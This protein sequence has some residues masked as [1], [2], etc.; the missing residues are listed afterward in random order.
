MNRKP[1]R[2][3]PPADAE[4]GEMMGLHATGFPQLDDIPA[5]TH[6]P[7][8]PPNVIAERWE[9]LRSWVIELQERFAHLDHHVIPPC[10]W[11]HNEHVEALAALRDH[12]RVS[13]APMAPA[14]A[15][16]EWMRALRDIE[17]L[18]RTWTAEYACGSSH[19]ESPAT[20]HRPDHTGWDEHIADDCK[21]RQQRQTARPP[22]D[23]GGIPDS[24]SRVTGSDGDS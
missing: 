9:E 21:R 24:E 10:W 20:L 12:E 23:N 22:H 11:R 5:A 15:S 7:K 17:A 16:V 1:D 2:G 4:T 3:P 14:T 13:Y 6:W 18:L 19:R 8:L